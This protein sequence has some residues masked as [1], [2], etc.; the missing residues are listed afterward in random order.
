MLSGEKSMCSAKK[1]EPM[2]QVC[3]SSVGLWLL[4]ASSPCITNVNIISTGSHEFCSY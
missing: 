4:L 2:S 1:G 3:G